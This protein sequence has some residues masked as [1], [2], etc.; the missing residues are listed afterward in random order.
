MNGSS[1]MHSARAAAIVAAIALAFLARAQAF[2]DSTTDT[3]SADLTA[4]DAVGESEVH[5][6]N[7]GS[8]AGSVPLR[9][10]A[11][12]GG[13]AIVSMLGPIAPLEASALSLA[14][15]ESLANES[16]FGVIG[17]GVAFALSA[18]TRWDDVNSVSTYGA[19]SSGTELVVAFAA[20]FYRGQSTYLTIQ[21]S[22]TDRAANVQITAIKSIA[23]TPSL[24]GTLEIE[25]GGSAGFWL[26]EGATKGLRDGWFGT[27]WIESDRPVSALALVSDESGGNAVY[28]VAGLRVDEG[29]PE[30]HVPRFRAQREVDDT[31]FFGASRIVVANPS[32]RIAVLV[33]A[34]VRGYAGACAGE[35]FESA[36]KTIR[37]GSNLVFDFGPSPDRD[38]YD[39]VVPEDCEG[40]VQLETS[41]GQVLTWAVEERWSSDFSLVTGAGAFQP[42]SSSDAAQREF[43]TVYSAGSTGVELIT[44][45]NTGAAPSE[46]T[47]TLRGEGIDSSACGAPCRAVVEPGASHVWK[48]EDLPNFPAEGIAAVELSADESVAML[49][50]DVPYAGGSDMSLYTG[51]PLS[52]DADASHT[53]LPITLKGARLS[54]PHRDPTPTATITWT[55]MPSVI[56][57]PRGT[58]TITPTFIPSRTPSPTPTEVPTEIPLGEVW[59]QSLD[60][61]AE[62]EAELKLVARDGSVTESRLTG[63][64]GFGASERIDLAPFAGSLGDDLHG[65]VALRGENLGALASLHARRGA[66]V[67]YGPPEVGTDVIVPMALIDYLGQSSSVAVQNASDDRSIVVTVDLIPFGRSTF[68]RRAP[69]LSLPPHAARAYRLGIDSEFIAVPAPPEGF[70]GWMRVSADGPVSV[71]SIIEES[72][73]ARTVHSLSGVPIDSA[74]SRHA[75][76]AIHFNDALSST[77]SLFNP[78][79]AAVEATILYSGFDGACSGEQFEADAILIAAYSSVDAGPASG[80]GVL[81]EDCIA[82]AVITSDAPII[83][84]VASRYPDPSGVD[85]A[86]GAFGYPAVTD[87]ALGSKLGLPRLRVTSSGVTSSIAMMNAGGSTA[88]AELTIFDESGV[89]VDACGGPCELELGPGEGGMWDLVDMVGL[90]FGFIGSGLISSSTELAVVVIDVPAFP[91]FDLSAY[92]GQPVERSAPPRSLPML[93][94]AIKPGFVVGPTATA[95]PWPTSTP[96]PTSHPG[97]GASDLI[98]IQ[99]LNESI[100]GSFVIINLLPENAVDVTLSVIRTSGPP[101]ASHRIDTRPD[102]SEDFGPLPRAG[103]YSSDVPV[104]VVG[105]H[106]YPGGAVTAQ[107]ASLSG[108]DLIVPW[109]V[110]QLGGP[111]SSITIM[112]GTDIFVP[113]DPGGLLGDAL[114]ELFEMGGAEPIGY[115]ETHIPANTFKHL[116]LDIAF[117]DLDLPRDSEGRF[118]G[119]MRITPITAMSVQTTIGRPEIEAARFS[120]A[121]VPAEIASTDLWAPFVR[122]ASD[123]FTSDVMVFNPGGEPAEVSLNYIGHG[124]TCVGERSAHASGAVTVA[125]FDMAVLSQ[126]SG[127]SGLPAGCEAAGVLNA[128]DAPVLAWVLDRDGE[129]RSAA[130]DL[131]TRFEIGQRIALPLL[132]ADDEG[133]S[134]RIVLHNADATGAPGPREATLRLWNLIG[135]EI[136]CDV[137]TVTL[138]PGESVTLDVA[139]LE[140]VPD[141]FEGSGEF[142]SDGGLLAVVIDAPREG[143]GDI[144]MWRGIRAEVAASGAQLLPITISGDAP[145]ITPGPPPTPRPTSTPGP[146]PTPWTVVDRTFL[147]HTVVQR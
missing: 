6:L 25:A 140:G 34:T 28:D 131:F 33:T 82:N 107:N 136:A 4:L 72:S 38:V 8:S 89:E 70:R 60:E 20:K 37:A 112:S 98:A 19:S 41:L 1:A 68:T 81:P 135:T 83:A 91:G 113:G 142:R 110:D 43:A 137:C 109:V 67:S 92:V 105:R 2:L 73:S 3:A 145:L 108:L 141:D 143:G 127:Q 78:G 30:W 86:A 21:N 52:G 9:F 90:D 24:T 102:S 11:P 124:G 120:V 75:A 111:S 74:A 84:S 115:I 139:D 114:I 5:V 18:R 62:I 61:G 104:G 71:V 76:P 31:G 26:G 94:F 40:T 36:T 16:Q 66:A 63:L 54:P 122:N 46:L 12:G 118:I 144:S 39:V 22:D 17:G 101:G 134:T 59:L 125:P 48:R 32:R 93:N 88:T 51:V 103:V 119:W 80:D 56:H 117:P 106:I 13:D 44:G 49:I 23:A 95:S 121:G 133:R 47:L 126:S 132:Y 116:D 85:R 77:I 123:G 87:A 58:P 96:R 65:G 69:P 29:A 130:Y 35:T 14:D 42:R 15:V 45:M 146:S 53:R 55:P 99:N 7:R 27:L 97:S 50:D 64:L 147:P 100:M 128:G 57:P 10:A 79:S 138:E 129:S